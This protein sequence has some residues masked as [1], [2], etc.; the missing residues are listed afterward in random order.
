MKYRKMGSLDWDVS[1]L[2]FG[3]MRLP[4]NK[5]M[6]INEEEAIKM[7]RYAIDNGVTYVDTAYPYHNG[8]SEVVV[9]K[10][11]KDGYREKVHLT[12][13][14][15]V[16]MIKKREDFDTFL[17]EQIERLQTTPDIYLLHGLNRNR[18][19]KIKDLNLIEKMEDAKAKGLIKYIGFSF[20]DNL[21]VF[22]E[23]VDY[24]NWDCCQIQYNYLDIDYQAGTEGVKYV[25]DKGIA[26]II[27]EPIRGGKLAI[28]ER[29]LDRKP[30][31]K[32]VLN[33]AEV[34]RSMPDWALQF[35]WNHPEVSVVLSGMS[36][37]QQVIENVESAKNSEMNSL[38]KNDLKTISKL[39]EAY[40][41][42]ILIPCTSCGYCI[43]CP[44]GVAI[45]GVF[46][47]V[48][49]LYYWGDRGRPRIAFFYSR[50]AK[51][52]ENFQKRKA[53]GEEVDGAATLC[54]Q[55]GECLD[56][57]PQQIDI[58]TFMEHANS[59]FEDGKSISE[60]FDQ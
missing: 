47:I 36:T 32:E 49:D 37:M 40:S 16:W 41:K 20:H 44:N 55:C 19:Q 11:L 29:V 8:E 34:K 33:E 2:G 1:A 26:L 60:V 51:T 13:K 25:G 10:A 18:L 59:L 3:A 14:S 53:D 58:P 7:I 4:I 39:R 30:E 57:C 31:I 6:K 48:N 17:D 27:M 42:Y 46:R 15:P 38:T 24:F 56:K 22:K 28:P 5:Q 50:M 9:G 45:P 43:P 35:V 52:E 23:I 12:T 54:I 21:E